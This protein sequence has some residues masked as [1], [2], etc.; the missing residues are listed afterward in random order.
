MSVLVR[1]R[2]YKRQ[3]RG[4][5]VDSN[6]AADV[7]KLLLAWNKGDRG[8]LNLLMPLV[9]DELRRLAR[10]YMR[11][12]SPGHTLQATALVND[13]YIRLVDQ[14][15]VNWQNR[16]QFFGVAAQIIRRV[17]VDHARARHRLKRGGDALRVELNEGNIATKRGGMDIIALDDVLNRLANMDPQKC[18][19]IELRFFGGLSIEETARALNISPAT[20][21]REWAFA[22]SW[23]Y[24][25]MTSR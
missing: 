23:L 16:A 18:Q 20:I 3:L 14:T 24:K 25:E 15:R 22:R 17:L 13:A 21:K 9:Y 2:V 10:R 6:Q 7:T 8:A 4:L 12:E 1:Q 11:S 19:I 5:S